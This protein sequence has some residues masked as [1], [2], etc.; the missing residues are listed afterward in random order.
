MECT[1]CKVELFW[2]EYKGSTVYRDGTELTVVTVPSGC[3]DDPD[4]EVGTCCCGEAI[5]VGHK[6]CSDLTYTK[7]CYENM[8][9]V[10][11]VIAKARLTACTACNGCKFEVSKAL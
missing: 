4:K 11:C 9:W 6:D 5:W 1:N 2:S 8:A 7:G 3:N 10:D